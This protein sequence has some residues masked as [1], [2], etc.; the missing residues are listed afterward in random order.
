LCKEQFAFIALAL[1]VG[2]LEEHPTCKK[3]SD[4]VLA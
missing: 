4:G 2:H 3:L 1:L